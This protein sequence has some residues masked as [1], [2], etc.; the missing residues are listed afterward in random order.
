MNYS[1][2]KHYNL[3]LI[4][5]YIGSKKAG[6][7]TSVPGNPRTSFPAYYLGNIAASVSDPFNFKGLMVQFKCNNFLDKVYYSPGIR[8]A[9]GIGNP[10]EIL[11]MGRNYSIRVNYEF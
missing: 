9:N 1:L 8:R 4:I 11:Q 6:K 5:N 2:L 3:N 10:N 7:G